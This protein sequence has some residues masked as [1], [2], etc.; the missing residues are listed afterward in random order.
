[1]HSGL[2]LQQWHRQSPHRM[3]ARYF[4]VGYSEVF[5]TFPPSSKKNVLVVPFFHSFSSFF[6]KVFI[7]LKE[8]LV[9]E[10]CLAPLLETD[11]CKYTRGTHSN[12]ESC[13][14]TIFTFP[15]SKRWVIMTMTWVFCSH[16]IFQNAEKVL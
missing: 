12:D 8:N 15:F 14:V 11:G 1:M 7:D 16:T 10:G 6:L 13:P 2:R 3:G 5:I 4:K 9:K